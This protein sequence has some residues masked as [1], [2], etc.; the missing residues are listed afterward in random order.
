M[1]PVGF[2][3]VCSWFGAQGSE[4]TYSSGLAGVTG[5]P[6]S[7]EGLQTL[8]SDDDELEIDEDLSGGDSEHFSHHGTTK[9]NMHNLS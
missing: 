9:Q 3:V 7:G 5:G 4:A 8:M 2:T 6:A 1:C